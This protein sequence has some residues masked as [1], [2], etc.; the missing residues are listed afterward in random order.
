MLMIDIIAKIFSTV[1]EITVD[2]VKIFA[3]IPA[4]RASTGSTEVGK[5]D[6]TL[7][8]VF[9]EEENICRNVS[10]T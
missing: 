3:E 4:D 9:G 5:W 1:R 2:D 7:H 10:T 8:A 6:Y